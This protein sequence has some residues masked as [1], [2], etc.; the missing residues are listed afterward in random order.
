MNDDKIEKLLCQGYIAKER[1]KRLWDSIADETYAND[2][3]I[4][5]SV[6]HICERICE[7]MVEYEVTKFNYTDLYHGNHSEQIELPTS[8]DI[9]YD[10]NCVYEVYIKD[11][12]LC[13]CDTEEGE[14]LV[15]DLSFPD[16]EKLA[17]LIV[18]NL[19]KK[20]NESHR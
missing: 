8:W 2:L 17:T 14:G 16:V 5:E 15:A 4:E 7:L 11:G 3:I 19:P 13:Y 18:D 9:R 12:S 10:Y 1:N 20:E 6:Q